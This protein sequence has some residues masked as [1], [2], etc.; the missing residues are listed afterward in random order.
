MPT[1]IQLAKNFCKPE[2]NLVSSSNQ[3]AKI[4]R[5]LT[6]LLFSQDIVF[7]VL[8][9]RISYKVNFVKLQSNQ[10]PNNYKKWVRSK[11]SVSSQRKLDLC[12]PVSNDLYAVSV[13]SI[14]FLR[15][16]LVTPK[17]TN[18]CQI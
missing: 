1:L 3:L 4:N 7:S 11:L 18:H 2:A 15:N 16:F 17:N 6:R 8:V 5:K 13:Q 10:F 9:Q 12:I 14:N